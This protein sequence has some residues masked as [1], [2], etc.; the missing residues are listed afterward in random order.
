MKKNT[1]GTIAGIFGYASIILWEFSII[2]ITAI[3]LGIVGLV[4][5]KKENKPWGMALWGLIGGII[6]LVV[7]IYNAYNI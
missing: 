7:R 1:V 5:A 6:F 2:Q 3:I 4:A